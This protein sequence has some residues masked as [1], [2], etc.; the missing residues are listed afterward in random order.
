MNRR[1]LLA[2]LA[3]APL[4]VGVVGQAAGADNKFKV[5]K[6]TREKLQE[7]YFPN[8]ELTTHEGKKVRFYDDLI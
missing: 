4:A 5:T 8:F 1:K 6:S 2:T 3:V 7:R